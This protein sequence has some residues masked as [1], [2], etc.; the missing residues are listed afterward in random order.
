[1]PRII[2]P[3]TRF[4]Q[5][6]CLMHLERKRLTFDNYM[7]TMTSSETKRPSS[8]TKEHEQSSELE[9]ASESEASVLS[10]LLLPHSQCY[11]VCGTSERCPN[12][13]KS[14]FSL[15]STTPFITPHPP[16]PLPTSPLFMCRVW[17]RIVLMCLLEKASPPSPRPPFLPS[18]I[19]SLFPLIV[20]S[21]LPF[22]QSSVS[23]FLSHNYC[24]FPLQKS[25]QPRLRRNNQVNYRKNNPRSTR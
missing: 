13:P 18:H 9:T 15:K 21:I 1:M 14:Y 10:P 7:Q 19:P 5:H 3:Q 17:H 16:L 23:V 2:E 8:D 6:Y 20:L 12:R 25:N 11:T 24:Q 4:I 22:L